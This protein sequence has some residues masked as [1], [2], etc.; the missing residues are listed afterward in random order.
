M[1]WEHLSRFMQAE[2]SMNGTI[3][4]SPWYFDETVANIGPQVW[5]TEAIEEKI[6]LTDSRTDKHEQYLRSTAARPTRAISMLD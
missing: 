2:Y 3:A 4:I 6:K 1:R 5:T